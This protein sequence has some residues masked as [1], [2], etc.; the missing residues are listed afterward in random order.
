[1]LRSRQESSVQP[2]FTQGRDKGTLFHCTAPL[3]MGGRCPKPWAAKGHTQP[4]LRCS[5]AGNLCAQNTQPLT[6]LGVY[7]SLRRI[8]WLYESSSFS[9]QVP[10]LCNFPAAPPFIN[11]R[12]PKLPA[13]TWFP[14]LPLS[15]R[16][17]CSQEWLNWCSWLSVC[18]TNQDSSVKCPQADDR[19]G[20][21]AGTS[22]AEQEGMAVLSHHLQSPFST[23]PGSTRV[24]VVTP[25]STSSS[26]PEDLLLLR[27]WNAQFPCTMI[28]ASPEKGCSGIFPVSLKKNREW[29]C[30][31]Q[32]I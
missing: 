18:A 25:E 21:A 15:S 16:G 6:S 2:S 24:S 27:C 7:F 19:R 9:I 20:R 5:F 28:L 17:W 4:G 13:Q 30:P 32:W 3:A 8:I 22:S 29:S 10:R 11:Q 1:M 23:I 14:H 26:V 12:R 31:L